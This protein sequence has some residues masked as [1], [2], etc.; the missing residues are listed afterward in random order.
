MD[1]LANRTEVMDMI[2][3]LCEDDL[4]FLNKL[5]VE[6]LKLISQAKSTHQMSRFNVGD[7]VSFHTNSGLKTGIIM[8]LNKKTASIKTDDGGNWNVSPSY[9]NIKN[10]E[11]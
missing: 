8:R 2:K 5:I 6:R 11:S 10:K 4:L 3:R 1:K 7:R 9:L